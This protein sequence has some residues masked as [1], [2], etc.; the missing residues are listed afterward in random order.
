MKIFGPPRAWREAPFG[1][2][3]MALMMFAVAGLVVFGVT[4]ALLVLLLVNVK[5]SGVRQ[6]DPRPPVSMVE[7][8]LARVPG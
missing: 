3:V 6:A 2:R 1:A 5:L 8:L 4:V 7:P